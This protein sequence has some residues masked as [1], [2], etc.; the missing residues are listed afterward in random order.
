MLMTSRSDPSTTAFGLAPSGFRLPA[1]TR[2]G[3]VRLQV[4]DLQRSLA[5]YS[6]V[7]GL[8][9]IAASGDTA[10]LGVPGSDTALVTLH[11]VAG[12]RPVPR[13]GAFGLFHFA[14]LLPERAALGRFLAHLG[15]TGVRVGMSDHKVSEALYLT[16]P[17]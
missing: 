12:T 2:V 11:H 10:I 5:Y 16:D 13:R 4:A 14:I 3:G 9:A 8:R 1:A 7:I 17:D 6:D 15:S